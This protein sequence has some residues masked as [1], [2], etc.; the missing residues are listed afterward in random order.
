MKIPQFEPLF[1]DLEKKRM[2]DYLSKGG[3]LTEFRETVKFSQ[4]LK[5]ITN[6]KSVSC[7][8]NGTI[9]LSIALKAL[10]VERGDK[11]LVPN[12]TMFATAS[13]AWFVGA[14][15]VFCDVRDDDFLL[16][17]SYAREM[18]TSEFKV[19]VITNAN[20]RTHTATEM[21]EFIKFCDSLEILV[22]EDSAQALGSYYDDGTHAGL[23]ADIGSLSF[24]VPKIITT[25][26]GGA[27]ITSSHDLGQK[28]N[29]LKDFGRSGGGND[30]HMEMGI[31]S[32]FTDLQAVIGQTQ[33]EDFEWRKRRKKEIHK[34]Y[35][36]GLRNCD[37]GKFVDYDT[38]HTVPWFY[39][40]LCEDKQY[41]AS[42][43]EKNYISTRDMYP[44]LNK[45]KALENHPQALD[46]FKISKHIE[47][48][49]LWLPSSLT[50]SDED[51]HKI[52][53]ILS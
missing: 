8:N 28:I 9:S 15:I 52:C 49:G 48:H 34:L 21:D 45:Q 23:K 11:V 41:V 4:M 12:F 38:S 35:K 39:E 22:L 16:D 17:L 46:E 40:F 31:N 24:S 50:L 6:S 19:V 29:L 32:K 43:L 27:L 18:L 1:T 20:G 47:K 25:G 42:I 26:Q 13:S 30:I 7:V 51:I 5:E 2:S 44:R 10:G 14:E 33:L 3:F 53:Q 37:K 36:D